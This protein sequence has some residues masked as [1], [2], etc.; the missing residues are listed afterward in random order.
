M[1][2]NETDPAI[3]ASELLT[4]EICSEE[5]NTGFYKFPKR[6]QPTIPSMIIP[7]RGAKF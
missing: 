2:P 6:D 5:T 3:P 4:A 7:A 1:S